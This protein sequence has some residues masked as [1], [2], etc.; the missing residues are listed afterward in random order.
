MSCLFAQHL[1]EIVYEDRVPKGELGRCP[2]CPTILPNTL[3]YVCHLIDVH[4]HRAP[5][6]K[7]AGNNGVCLHCLLNFYNRARLKT[8]L[9]GKKYEGSKCFRSLIFRNCEG[10]DEIQILQNDEKERIE[11]N[12]LKARGRAGRATEGMSCNRINGPVQE[13][14]FGAVPVWAVRI[15]I[16]V[17]SHV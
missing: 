2:L 15:P 14:H 1:K 8:H 11:V 9:A 4:G 5:E 7:Y 6:I 17:L 13:H 3:K 10:L 16:Q 12:A